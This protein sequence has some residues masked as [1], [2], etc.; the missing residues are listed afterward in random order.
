MAKKAVEVDLDMD[1]ISKVDELKEVQIPEVETREVQYARPKAVIEVNNLVNCL[2]NKKIIVRYVPKVSGLIT[3]PKHIYYGG[4]AETSFRSFTVPMLQSGKYVNILTT[5]EKD[6]LEHIMGLEI[7][8]LSIY[9]KN[10][11]YWDNY[12]VKLGKV[13]TILDLSN[14]E[15]YIKYKVLLANNEYIAPNIQTLQDRP[16]ETYQ[17]VI[18]EEG[19]EV[20]REKDNM[21]FTM[22][23]YMKFGEIK[24]KFD[25]LK[26]II[27]LID[28]RPVASNSKLVFLQTKINELIQRDAKMFIATVEDPYF[29]Q[30]VLIKNAIEER[31]IINRGNFL[32]LKSD[33]Q[34]LCDNNQDPT[35]SVAAAYL[36]QPKNQDLMFGIEAKLEQKKK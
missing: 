29:K 11:N 18:I 32:Y 33:G 25:V 16:K 26:T 14:P 24:E 21:T 1:E 6:Y 10:N 20:S 34:P 28:G 31:I 15:E 23:A 8:S 2:T 30:K 22:Q 13:D 3:N 12:M 27:E 36:S 9:K 19:Q 7:N 4:I 17:F 35:L 5:K